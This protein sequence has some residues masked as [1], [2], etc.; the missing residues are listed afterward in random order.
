MEIK[1]GTHRNEYLMKKSM[2]HKFMFHR[3]ELL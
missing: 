2:L 1:K 3:S